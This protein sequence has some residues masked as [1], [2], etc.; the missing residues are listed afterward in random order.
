MRVTL[1]GANGFVGSAFARLL[2]RRGVEL[3]PVTRHNYDDGGGTKSDVLIEAA[4]N[5]KKYVA[6]SQ[7]FK[8]FDD[9]VTHRLRTLR[10][11]PAG[12]HLH[13]SSVDVYN[14]LSSPETTREDTV[15]DRKCCSH[16]GFHKLLAE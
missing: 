9:S 15:I 6:Q 14:D 8:E 10:D 5:S 4:C 2:S 7:P 3:V 12:F 16:Y 13:L 1:I 11:Y